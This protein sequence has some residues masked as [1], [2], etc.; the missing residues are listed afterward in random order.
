MQTKRKP[1]SLRRKATTVGLLLGLVG[2]S[3]GLQTVDVEPVVVL[4]VGRVHLP[5]WTSL[6]TWASGWW[7]VRTQLLPAVLTISTSAIVG[8]ARELLHEFFAN[9]SE[10]ILLLELGLLVEHLRL[11]NRLGDL[12]RDVVGELDVRDVTGELD[13]GRQGR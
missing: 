12:L 5:A 4:S 8:P 10:V 1:I 13:V 2:A 9:G 7:T 6:P 11:L 3:L